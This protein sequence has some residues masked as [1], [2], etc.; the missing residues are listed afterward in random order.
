MAMVRQILT[1][2][3]ALAKLYIPPP[4]AEK[5]ITQIIEW[6][7]LHMRAKVT[8]TVDRVDGRQFTEIYDGRA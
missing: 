1:K 6:I 2:E 3:T 4:S 8:I 7:A 5:I